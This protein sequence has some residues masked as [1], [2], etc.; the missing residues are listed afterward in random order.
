MRQY[1]GVALAASGKRWSTLLIRIQWTDV[2]GV[3]DPNN[4]IATWAD[5][6]LRNLITITLEFWHRTEVVG[7][8]R[9]IEQLATVLALHCC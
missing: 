5:D 1:I 9:Q 3:R 4:P 8:G 7:T 2:A 6:R